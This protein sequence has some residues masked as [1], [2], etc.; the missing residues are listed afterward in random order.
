MKWNHL[1][2]EGGIYN[3]D[4]DLLEGFLYIFAKRA[5]HEEEE[6]KKREREKNRTTGG[7]G[8]VAGRR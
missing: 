8:R 6:N 1:P 5:E 7:P 3:Q 2:E 4:P